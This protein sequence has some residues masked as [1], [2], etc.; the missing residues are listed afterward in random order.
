MIMHRYDPIPRGEIKTLITRELRRL[1]LT[2]FFL[3]Y[4]SLFSCIA[5]RTRSILV[6]FYY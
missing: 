2:F 4:D 5:Y 3:H 1:F 6:S